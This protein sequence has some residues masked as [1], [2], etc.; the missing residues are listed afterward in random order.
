ME[1]TT[2]SIIILSILTMNFGSIVT[3]ALL[4]NTNSGFVA[5]HFFIKLS[6]HI[7]MKSLMDI[8][9]AWFFGLF[10][11]IT[12][13]LKAV[14][15]IAFFDFLIG[16]TLAIYARNFSWRKSATIGLKFVIYTGLIATI[17]QIETLLGIPKLNIGDWHFSATLF[18]AGI[19]AWADTKSII[20]NTK[21]ALGL[22][23]LSF[24]T[25]RF[26]MLKNFD[27]KNGKTEATEPISEKLG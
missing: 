9:V 19:I 20:E 23:A 2:L 11:P 26:P 25:E 22:E 4:Q 3:V 24:L 13:Y 12:I 5:K 14:Y 7:T 10:L 15:T 18:V 1:G 17:N 16:V 21:K 6:K 8:V 27:A